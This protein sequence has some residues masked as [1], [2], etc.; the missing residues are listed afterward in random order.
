MLIVSPS[1]GEK[2]D[3]RLNIDYCVS[4]MPHL[5]LP[6]HRSIVNQTCYSKVHQIL[7]TSGVEK[8]IKVSLRMQ[9]K[10]SEAWIT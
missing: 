1:E 4:T 5:V 3:G 6:G 10:E 8:I 2:Y 7:V 9:S